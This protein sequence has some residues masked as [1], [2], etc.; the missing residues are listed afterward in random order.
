[1]RLK[2]NNTNTKINYN[3][4]KIFDDLKD[5]IIREYVKDYRQRILFSP[6]NQWHDWCFNEACMRELSTQITGAKYHNG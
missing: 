1:M 5:W 3:D 4:P 6:H 2:T